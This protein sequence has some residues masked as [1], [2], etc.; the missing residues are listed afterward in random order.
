MPEENF[1]Q[2]IIGN[3]QHLKPFAFNFTKCHE[4]A[5]DLM[6]DTLL[7]AWKNRHKYHFGTNIR[8][9]LF[10]IM[11]NSFINEYRSKKLR[12]HIHEQNTI[13]ITG[14]TLLHA[15]PNVATYKLDEKYLLKALSQLPD[16]F[17]EPLELCSRGYR[18]LEIAGILNQSEGTIKSRI[19]FGRKLLK[20]ELN[21]R[22]L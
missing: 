15:T 6:Q 22:G 5:K 18:Y 16:I 11:R 8:A 20:E 13:A 12:S 14:N 3:Q 19:H 17:R 21:R 4:A 2:L 1:Q 7:L 10:T 9:W